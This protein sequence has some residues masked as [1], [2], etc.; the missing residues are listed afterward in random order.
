LWTEEQDITLDDGYFSTELGTI[1]AIPADLF[2]GSKLYLGVT[3]GNDDEMTPRQ[4]ISSVPYALLAGAAATVPFTGISGVPAACA[5]G[6]YLK[7]FAADGTAVCGAIPT[8]SCHTVF[9]AA[10]TAT[11]FAF[12]GCPT[13]EVPMGGG[14]TTNGYL[15]TSAFYHCPTQL[16]LCI[17][18]QPCPGGNDWSCSTTANATITPSVRCCTVQ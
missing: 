5:D 9:G 17:I 15:S 4:T 7:G 3:V 2:D 1:T 16:C 11:T 18:G 6:K 12:V 10:A 14:C 13:G 8:L